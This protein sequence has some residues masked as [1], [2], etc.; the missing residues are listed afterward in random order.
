METGHEFGRTILFMLLHMIDDT[1]K[2]PEIISKGIEFLEKLM[3]ILICIVAVSCY[4]IFSTYLN[5]KMILNVL[6]RLNRLYYFKFCY[7]V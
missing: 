3:L 6:I 4:K 7:I 5:K 2:I 1:R